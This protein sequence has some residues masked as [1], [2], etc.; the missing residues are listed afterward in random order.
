M[1]G[2]KITKITKK[3]QFSAAQFLFDQNT[4]LGIFYI[5]NSYIWASVLLVQHV[6]M[7]SFIS[8]F[9]IYIRILLEE[10][11][12]NVLKKIIEFTAIINNRPFQL[13]P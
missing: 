9:K 2:R 5:I 7:F 10:E 12:K 8:A 13:P 3:K 4:E 11:K 1:W 6:S